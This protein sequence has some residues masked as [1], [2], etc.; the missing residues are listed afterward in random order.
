VDDIRAKFADNVT[1][2]FSLSHATS[3]EAAILALSDAPDTDVLAHLL[4]A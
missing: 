2:R 4:S 1:R 3:L